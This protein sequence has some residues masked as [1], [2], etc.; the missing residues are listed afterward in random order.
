MDINNQKYFDKIEDKIKNNT[1][2]NNIEYINYY[3]KYYIVDDGEYIYLFDKKY[4]ELLKEDKI[5]FHENKN[6]YD[7]IYK[8]KK[9]MYLE[10]KYT[11]KKIKYIYY[12][13][14]TY[15]EIETIVVGG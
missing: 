11:K 15:E 8:D 10:E 9:L 12:D 6:N 7:I 5:K 13:I 4:N 2:I 3:N 14:K 1:D